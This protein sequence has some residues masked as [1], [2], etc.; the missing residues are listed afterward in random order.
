ML[1]DAYD[2][3]TRL[4]MWDFLATLVVDESTGFMFMNN[5]V[6]NTINKELKYTGHSGASYAFTMRTMESIAKNGWSHYVK[7]RGL[8]RDPH[9]SP[10]APIAKNP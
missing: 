7:A 3:I 8:K 1:K 2:T 4:S 6:I 5:P 9:A 10:T